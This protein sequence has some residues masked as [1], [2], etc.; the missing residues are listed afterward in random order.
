MGAILLCAGAKNKRAALPHSRVMIHQPWGGAQG[1]ASDIEIQAK[2]I[3]KTKET[4]TNILVKH[5]KRTSAQ[6]IK[7]TDRNY[8]MSPEEA[9][10]Y[11]IIDNITKG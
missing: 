7:D 11:G 5:T 1:Q 9:K 8:F 10:K 4:L 6:V 3:M 2:E